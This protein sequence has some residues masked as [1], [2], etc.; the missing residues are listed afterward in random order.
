MK[1]PSLAVVVARMSGRYSLQ[2]N[3]NSMYVVYTERSHVSHQV[4]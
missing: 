2:V 1:F 4:N 3:I